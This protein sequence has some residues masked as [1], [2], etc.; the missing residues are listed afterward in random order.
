MNVE[1]AGDAARRVLEG[2][3][4]EAERLGHEFI[5]AEH[6]LLSLLRHDPSTGAALESLGL[7]VDSVRGRL[8]SGGRRPR[9]RAE[10]GELAYTSAARRLIEIASK[11]ARDRNAALAPEHLLL[12]AVHEP[13]GPIARILSDA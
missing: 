9:V 8:E 5:G 10:D 6:I 11:E 1:N 13:R 4:I 2:A 3:R 7:A 12:A